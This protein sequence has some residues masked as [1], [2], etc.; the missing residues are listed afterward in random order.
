MIL[1]NV[2]LRGVMDGIDLARE[3]KMRWPLLPVIL[4]SGHPSERVGELP[5]GVAYMRKP[6]RPLNVLI[7]AEQALASRV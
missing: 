3:V 7:A 2:W 1:A 4:T 5:P 6:W